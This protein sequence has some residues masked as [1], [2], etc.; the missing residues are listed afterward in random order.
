MR[1]RSVE[2]SG[3]YPISGMFLTCTTKSYGL[4]GGACSTPTAPR[5]FA[6]PAK[7][8]EL[9]TSAA[10]RMHRGEVWEVGPRAFA[11]VTVNISA[12]TISQRNGSNEGEQNGTKAYDVSMK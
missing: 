4:P 1:P 11:R 3:L 2:T 10:A 6:Q 9:A 12:A 8:A 5:V 7:A